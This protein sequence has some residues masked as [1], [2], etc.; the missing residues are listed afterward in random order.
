MRRLR[1]H[2][3]GVGEAFDQALGNTSV[4]VEAES[5][6]ENTVRLLV[7]CG[8]SVPQNLFSRFPD[9]NLLDGVY[10]THFHADH[11]FGFPGLV[12]RLRGAGR[13]RPL[14]LIGQ[15]GTKERLTAIYELAY[16]GSMAKAPFPLEFIE[17][18]LDKPQLD[19]NG[20]R[21]DFAELEHPM[22]NFGIRIDSGSTAVGISGDG[23]MTDA[24][25]RLFKTVDVLVHEAF[26]YETIGENP[27]HNLHSS[28]EDVLELLSSSSAIRTVALVHICRPERAR[29]KAAIANLISSRPPGRMGRIDLFIPEPG[30]CILS[31][32]N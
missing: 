27:L 16:P 15:P 30:D 25:K 9:P 1:T 6:S 18:S 13:T 5:D 19:W 24:S 31:P 4:L 26:T 12:G 14:T 22:R 20:L 3:I 17:F 28:V 2:F 32:Q 23:A 10:F 8:Y 7:D 21:L 29:C 11:S